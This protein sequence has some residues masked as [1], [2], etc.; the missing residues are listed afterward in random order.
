MNTLFETNKPLNL[1]QLTSLTNLLTRLSKEG[2]YTAI[3][4]DSEVLGDV[5]VLTVEPNPYYITSSGT[6][7]TSDFTQ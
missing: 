3:I 7:C 6:V 2:I 1:E 4:Q 5:V